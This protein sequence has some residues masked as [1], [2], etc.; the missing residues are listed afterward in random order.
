MKLP[1]KDSLE[2]KSKFM[3][4]KIVPDKIYDDT[5]I[6]KYIQFLHNVLCGSFYLDIPASCFL[7]FHG[8][9]FVYLKIFN[10]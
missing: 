5:P 8:E 6:P 2:T 3:S 4:P 7:E 1:K 10:P 9:Y